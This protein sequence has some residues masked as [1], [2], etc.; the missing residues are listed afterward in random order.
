MMLRPEG[1]EHQ[2]FS[3]DIYERASEYEQV[4]KICTL[5][6]PCVP[7]ISHIKVEVYTVIADKQLVTFKPKP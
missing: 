2:I 5:I 3:F 6:Q 4:E 1:G 7:E